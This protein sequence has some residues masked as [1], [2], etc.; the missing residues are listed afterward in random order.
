MRADTHAAKA[1]EWALTNS[2]RLELAEQRTLVTGLHLGAA[3]TDMMAGYDGYK[4]A[5]EVIVAAALDGIEAH[6]PEVLAD[7]WSRRVKAWLSEDPDLIYREV[8]AALTV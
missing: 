3:D 4:S 1:A 7:D 2:V 8:A 6:R 5:P